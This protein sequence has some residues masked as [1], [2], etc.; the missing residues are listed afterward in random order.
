M[1]CVGNIVNSIAKLNLEVVHL[2]SVGGWDAPHP[3]A[4]N[5]AEVIYEALDN[6][7]KNVVA[8]PN[9]GFH[10]FDGFDW[11]IEGNDNVNSPYNNFT[12]ACLDVMGRI[13]QLAKSNGYIVTMAPPESYLDPTTSEFSRSL[14]YT[15]P[16]WNFL[17]PPFAYHGRN[18]YAYI[19]S[20]YGKTGSVDTFDSIFVQ[21]Y[22]T[23]SHAEYQIT[24]QRG[25]AKDWFSYLI[26]K[27]QAGWVVNFGSDPT[28]KYP[29]QNLQISPKQIVIGLANGWAGDGRV[30]L[31]YPEDVQVAHEYMKSEG[32]EPKGY[33]FWSIKQEGEISRQRP[34]IPVWMAAGLNKFL[35]IRNATLN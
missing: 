20:R 2:I 5:T 28:V 33:G 23:Y 17:Q 26:K 9:L 29:S 7:N 34:G 25:S 1:D 14:L 30:L 12:V 8:R 32:I 16:E 4:T 15:Y 24:H 13:S 18:C 3:D 22:E 31:V 10:G 11:D 35:Q 6:W 27:F 21:L 19:V